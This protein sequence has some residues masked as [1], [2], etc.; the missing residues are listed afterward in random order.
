[1]VEDQMTEDGFEVRLPGVS[2]QCQ[3]HSMALGAEV[4]GVQHGL[5]IHAQPQS[6]PFSA[7][8]T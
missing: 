7:W 8:L 1:M 4:T 5:P 3:V 6:Q 2:P